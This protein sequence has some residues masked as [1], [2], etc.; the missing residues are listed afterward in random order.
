M[1]P[2]VKQYVTPL[3]KREGAVIGSYILANKTKFGSISILGF[4]TLNPDK[5]EFEK[6]DALKE[7]NLP[8]GEVEVIKGIYFKNKAKKRHFDLRDDNK[9]HVL[10]RVPMTKIAHLKIKHRVLSTFVDEFKHYTQDKDKV[11]GHRFIILPIG[12]KFEDK[13]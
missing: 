9:T 1:T 12:Y 4:E 7:F 2:E 6:V 3:E 8:Y 5:I 10:V 11:S 13:K